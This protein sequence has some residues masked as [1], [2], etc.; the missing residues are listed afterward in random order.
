MDLLTLQRGR[1]VRLGVKQAVA[2]RG[3]W[4]G[5]RFDEPGTWRGR[6]GKWSAGNSD[7][8]SA[9]ATSTHFGVPGGRG[10][11]QNGAMGTQIMGWS[12]PAPL[13]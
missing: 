10:R 12:N 9:A 5:D 3:K 1:G 7:R 8:M 11:G 4:D 13:T 2:G 6:L